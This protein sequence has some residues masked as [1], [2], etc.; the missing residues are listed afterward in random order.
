MELL[1]DEA[2]VDSC[3]GPFGVSVS[4]SATYVHG[5]FQTRLE[6]HFLPHPIELLGDE[7]QVESHFRP[8]RYSVS[9]SAR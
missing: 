1:G 7:G 4:I 9:I 5:F 3:F 2:Q 8:F 6:N